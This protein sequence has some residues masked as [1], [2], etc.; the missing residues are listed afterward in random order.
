MFEKLPFGG[1]KKEMI[2]TPEIVQCLESFKTLLSNPVLK[3]NIEKAAYSAIVGD[4]LSGRIPTLIMTEI[5][6][7]VYTEKKEKF[8]KTFFITPLQSKTFYEKLT[9]PSVAKIKK[10]LGDD[11]RKVLVVTEYMSLGHNIDQ[12][13]NSLKNNNLQADVVSLEVSD[14]AKSSINERLKE[15]YNSNLFVGGG[16]D[17]LHMDPKTQRHKYHLTGLTRPDTWA[18]LPER[19]PNIP[20]E[21]VKQVHKDAK[22]AAEILYNKFFVSENLIKSENK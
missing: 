5:M 3:E 4:D 6:K 18:G 1:R 19:D 9:E 13:V 7:K 2:Q 16:G 17:F 20:A 21:K 14:N 12:I 22:L 10:E 8:R 15:R 11:K